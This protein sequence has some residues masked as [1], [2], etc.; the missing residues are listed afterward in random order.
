MRKLATLTA[1]AALGVLFGFP[2][3]AQA[4]HGPCP[5]VNHPGC[6]VHFKGN[7]FEAP[8]VDVSVPLQVPGSEGKVNNVNGQWKI[9]LDTG[10]DDTAFEICFAT[11]VGD[12]ILMTDVTTVTFLTNAMSDEDGELLENGFLPAD[13]HEAFRFEIRSG[14][15]GDCDGDLDFVSGFTF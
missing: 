11:T 14:S 3:A 5:N 13:T 12:S 2:S 8:F 10:S 6:G 1:V 9:D 15:L 4:G 7:A